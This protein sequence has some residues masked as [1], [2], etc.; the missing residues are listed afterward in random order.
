ML[1]VRDQ[2]SGEGGLVLRACGV[3]LE[4]RVAAKVAQ[5]CNLLYRRIGFGVA[6]LIGITGLV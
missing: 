5:I 6:L 1:L 3:A 2:Q 4:Q